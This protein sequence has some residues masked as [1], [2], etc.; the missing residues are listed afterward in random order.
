VS[1]LVPVKNISL[2]LQA[3]KELRERGVNA[4][5]HIAGEGS[6]RSVLVALAQTLRLTEFITFHGRQTGFDLGALYVACD[7]FL[8][9]STS[10]GYGMVLIEA[11]HAGLPIIT[12]DVGCV[13]E[14]IVN[15]QNALVVEESDP[16]VLA[17]ALMRLQQDKATIAQL[18][19]GMRETLQTLPTFPETIM[20]YTQ[21]WSR[22]RDCRKKV[23]E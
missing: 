18:T 8:L 5:L 7:C 2:Q 4:H 9:T 10:E 23:D 3:L 16:S 19:S 17:D 11:L 13:G 15:E 12:T 14:V 1:R 22:A 6:E 20:L 21:T